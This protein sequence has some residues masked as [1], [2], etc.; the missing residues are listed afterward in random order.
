[1]SELVTSVTGKEA[2]RSDCRKIKGSYYIKNEEC[3][4]INGKWNRFDN[5]NIM[6]NFDNGKYDLISNLEELNLTRGYSYDAENDLFIEGF[7][8][9]GN[10]TCIVS[11]DEGET[12]HMFIDYNLLPKNYKVQPNR[13][14]FRKYRKGQ[15]KESIYKLKSTVN[16]SYGAF[17]YDYNLSN[18]ESR[19]MARRLMPC[20]LHDQELEKL[21]GSR[22]TF[23]VELET[24]NGRVP[25]NMLLNNGFVA[26][27][28]GSLRGNDIYGYEYT[29]IPFKASN[30]GN[31][32]VVADMIQQVC[33]INNRCSLHFH[34]SGIEA[35]HQNAVKLY[36]AMLKLQD[37]IFS[38]FP[39]YKEDPSIIGKRKNHCKKFKKIAPLND[40]YPQWNE[41]VD[42]YKK[43]K[44]EVYE[45]LHTYI[46]AK[47]S[48]NDD[49]FNVDE[50]EAREMRSRIITSN[51]WNIK[52]RYHYVNL[53]N[54][55]FNPNMRTVEFRLHTGT[56][57]FSVMYAWLLFCKTLLEFVENPEHEDQIMLG[58]ITLEDIINY[59]KND[60]AIRI[61]Q[62]YFNYRK[63]VVD[64]DGS[65]EDPFAEIDLS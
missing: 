63:T 6:L 57:S 16:N 53:V 55:M 52:A 30:L 64:D 51:K 20:K 46:F 1:M 22:W 48:T 18:N 24:S 50:T 9:M 29:S 27:R 47:F 38:Y 39:R 37:E 42:T 59:S 14:Y 26:L 41:Y 32:K 5:G 25:Q 34:L 2:K 8:T 21:I 62:N 11:F 17:K 49:S 19:Q 4:Y 7:F 35:N 10:T 60:R 33:S 28:D 40:S 23:G 58:S 44:N 45:S 3:F 13:D 31:V 36:M 54:F 12:T 65:A 56:G 61:L 15:T 43:N